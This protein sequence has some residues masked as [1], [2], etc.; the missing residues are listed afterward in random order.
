MRIKHI[1][2]NLKKGGAERLALN[3]VNALQPFSKIEVQLLTFGSENDYQFLTNTIKWKVIH[4]KV[5]LSL[6]GK[7]IIDVQQLQDYIDS[8]QNIQEYY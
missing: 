4:S 1:I 6:S 5:T 2:P 3:S 8:F 7:S